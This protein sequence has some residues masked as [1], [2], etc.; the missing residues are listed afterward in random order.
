MNISCKEDKGQTE[1]SNDLYKYQPIGQNEI[2]ILMLHS[3]S[4]SNLK[5]DLK[6]F[7][8]DQAPKYEAVSY[9]WGDSTLRV[10]ITCENQI[11]SIT[12][13]LHSALLHFRSQMGDNDQPRVLWADGICIDQSNL[14]ERS[15][16]VRLMG[17]IYTNAKPVLVWLGEGDPETR[18]LLRKAL[19]VGRLSDL[20]PGKATDEMAEQILKLLSAPWFSRTWIIQ[21]VALADEVLIWYGDTRIGWDMVQ[22]VAR[23]LITLIMPSDRGL[24]LLTNF[25]N[26]NTICRCRRNNSQIDPFRLLQECRSSIATDPRDKIYAMIGLFNP[27]GGVDFTIQPDYRADVSK[28]YLDFAIK[29]L[30]ATQNLDLLSVPRAPPREGLPLWAPRWDPEVPITISDVILKRIAA[31]R[32]IA[33]AG[34]QHYQPIF[35][36]DHTRLKISGHIIGTIEAV[37]ET[38]QSMPQIGNQDALVRKGPTIIN[39]GEINDWLQTTRGDIEGVYFTGEPMFDAHWKTHIAGAVSQ[40]EEAEFRE[41]FMQ[42]Y[43]TN[44][45]DLL[46]GRRD[47][48]HKLGGERRSAVQGRRF[49]RTSEG[50]IGL[51]PGV[52]A[53]GDCVGVFEGGMVPLVLRLRGENWEL[54]GDCYVHGVM[55][56]EAFEEGSCHEFWL[57]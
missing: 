3:G 5:C 48:S 37:S 7:T 4:N 23:N 9:C 55:L 41:D 8:L 16:Q 44:I 14:D 29:S 26:I 22:E 46:L 24:F 30:Q 42:L 12:Q 36:E 25:F 15:D 56:G 1:K 19:V 50:M 45:S 13:G 17:Q 51:A 6:H 28:V 33:W 40:E 52:A 20:K 47:L 39:L 34:T 11:L 21:E 2:R 27:P 38:V 49:M 32:Q 43:S 57:I 18:D 54:L 35:S 31:T 53:V 10:N